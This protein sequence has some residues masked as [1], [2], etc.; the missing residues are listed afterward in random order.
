MRWTVVI[1]ETETGIQELSAE[2]FRQHYGYFVA[3]MAAEALEAWL[4]S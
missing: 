3:R 2:E 1:P 4:A